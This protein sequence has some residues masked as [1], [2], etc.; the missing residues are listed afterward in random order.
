M[1]RAVRLRE[2]PL[3]E[4]RLY[5]YWDVNAMREGVTKVVMYMT[6]QLLSYQIVFISYF[7]FFSPLGEPVQTTGI[8]FLALNTWF[9]IQA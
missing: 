5:C 7:S 4:L 2:C 8:C 1:S 3:R 6:K 9:G